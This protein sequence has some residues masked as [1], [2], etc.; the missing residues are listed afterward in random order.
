M[1]VVLLIFIMSNSTLAGG[2]DKFGRWR[3]RYGASGTQIPGPP[4]IGFLLADNNSAYD[5]S[6]KRLTNLAVEPTALNDAVTLQYVKERCLYINPGTKFIGCQKKRL[7]SLADPIDSQD[8]VTKAALNRRVDDLD[9]ELKSL[10][11]I[12]KEVISKCEQLLD[13]VIM[14][15]AKSSLL[16]LALQLKESPTE[17]LSTYKKLE[18]IH[19]A[20]KSKSNI[21]DR[22]SSLKRDFFQS[23]F[24]RNTLLR[25]RDIFNLHD[26]D[27]PPDSFKVTKTKRGGS[28]ESCGW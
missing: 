10:I 18:E 14:E 6:G 27:I 21:H 13:N 24:D 25:V 3:S 17:Y 5:M 26:D 11:N 20:V 12:N 8:G 7:V 15:H 9:R 23:Q 4:G 28:R 2:I 22:L 1:V 19:I 16:S